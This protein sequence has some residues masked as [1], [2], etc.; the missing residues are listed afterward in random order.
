MLSVYSV[1][2]L[3]SLGG[4]QPA[5]SPMRAYVVVV[6]PP[7][8]QHRPSMAEAAEQGLVQALVSQPPVEALDEGV[9]GRLAGRDIVPL[10][11]ALLRPAQDGRGGQFRPIARQEGGR[12]LGSGARSPG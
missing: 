1:R 5:Q 7:C 2:K 11:P 10:D 4:R 3:G 9:L 12:L 6:V 8:A